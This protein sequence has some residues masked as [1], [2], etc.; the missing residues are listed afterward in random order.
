MAKLDRKDILR[1]LNTIANMG[2]SP[3]ALERAMKRGIPFVEVFLIDSAV[4]CR[5]TAYC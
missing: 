1:S 4:W 5:G 3:E 2:P